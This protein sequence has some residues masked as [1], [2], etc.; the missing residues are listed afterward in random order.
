L[1]NR[2][3][4]D[5]SLIK[6]SFARSRRTNESLSRF[7]GFVCRWPRAGGWAGG[8]GPRGAELHFVVLRLARRHRR[9][10]RQRPHGLPAVVADDFADRFEGWLCRIREYVPRRASGRREFRKA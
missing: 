7:E 4:S 6:D 3:S 8:A 9:L 2:K 5:E 1:P 10:G